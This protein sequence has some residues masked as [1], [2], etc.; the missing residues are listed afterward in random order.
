MSAALAAKGELAPE[1]T[2]KEDYIKSVPRP[3][4]PYYFLIQKDLVDAF[5]VYLPAATFSQADENGMV[6]MTL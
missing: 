4:G 1:V 3:R 5:K 2:M 6:R